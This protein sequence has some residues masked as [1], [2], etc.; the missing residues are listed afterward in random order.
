[1]MVEKEEESIVTPKILAK[2]GI[3]QFFKHW[4]IKL[5]HDFF[6]F[7]FFFLSKEILELVV[8]TNT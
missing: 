5:G 1:M 3:L 8:H 2:R 6:S 7:R 4:C